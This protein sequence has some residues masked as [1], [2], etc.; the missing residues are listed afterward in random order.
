MNTNGSRTAQEAYQIPF[1]LRGLSTAEVAQGPGSIPQHAN[2][3]VLAQKSE[4]GPEG[5]LLEDIIP[6]LWAVTSDVPQR[7]NSL[8]SDVENR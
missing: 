4:E 3:V 1:W 8:L 7:P 6:A 5:T 2:F